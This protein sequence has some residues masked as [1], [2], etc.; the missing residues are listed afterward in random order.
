MDGAAWRRAA[1]A[2][3]RRLRARVPR[4]HDPRLA[5]P[6]AGPRAAPDSRRPLCRGA[7]R[8][9]RR[10]LAVRNPQRIGIAAMKKDDL[11]ALSASELLLLY[12]KKAVSPVEATRAVLERIEKLN[13][14]LNAFCFLD[15]ESALK[16]AKKS[17][18]RWRKN[19][20][21]GLLDGVPASIKDLLLTKG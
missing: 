7:A 9:P 18:K 13:P 4:H 2:R 16:A 14:I 11:C 12:R 3:H 5:L 15:R 21:K 8:G 6:Y 17:E 19:K 10:Q 20:P 1:P